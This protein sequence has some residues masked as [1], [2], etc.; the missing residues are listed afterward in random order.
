M[1]EKEIVDKLK[2]ELEKWVCTVKDN[3]KEDGEEFEG[4]DKVVEALDKAEFFYQL[5]DW[6]RERSWDA[7]AWMCFVLQQL[8]G[9][10]LQVGRLAGMDT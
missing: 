1:T 4:Y 9:V 6:V 2:V 10:T 7:E 3:M 5:T 8:V